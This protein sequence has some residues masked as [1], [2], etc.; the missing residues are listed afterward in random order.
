[1]YVSSLDC[2]MHNDDMQD[3]R[4]LAHLVHNPR[5]DLVHLVHNTRRDRMNDRYSMCSRDRSRRT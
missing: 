4:N 2:I 3:F 5:R 1:M